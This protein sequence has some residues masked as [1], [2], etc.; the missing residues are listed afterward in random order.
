[1]V[2]LHSGVTLIYMSLTVN[3][4]HSAGLAHFSNFTITLHVVVKKQAVFHGVKA[5]VRV[6]AFV[7]NV[8]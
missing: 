2:T 3:F 4:K 7:R 1:M 5:E 8:A 6:V